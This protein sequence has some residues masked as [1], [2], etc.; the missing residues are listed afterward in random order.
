MLWGAMVENAS[1]DFTVERRP[2][3]Y[4]ELVR[5]GVA[6]SEAAGAGAGVLA[7]ALGTCSQG[8]RRNKVGRAVSPVP[9][10]P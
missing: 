6:G 2:G 10:S 1:A 3:P 5:R 7:L 9:S 8:P 4:L